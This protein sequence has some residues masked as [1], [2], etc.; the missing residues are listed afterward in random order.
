MCLT[1]A[2]NTPTGDFEFL[3][4]DDEIASAEVVD[5]AIGESNIQPAS[6]EREKMVETAEVAKQS[7]EEIEV[8][9]A[10]FK[11]RV[12]RSPQKIVKIIKPST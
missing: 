1:T 8:G 11:F 7:W 9:F 5:R 10:S 4:A 2:V 12:K 3:Y 6:E